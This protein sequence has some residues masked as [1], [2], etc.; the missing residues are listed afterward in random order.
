MTG[1]P[2]DEWG[3][4]TRFLESARLAFARERESW[5]SSGIEYPEQV[6]ITAPQ[7]HDS[8]ALHKHMDAVDDAETLDGSVLVHSY[9]LAEA[10]AAERMQMNSR[11]LAGIEDWGCEAHRQQW[12]R[13]D[14][15]EGWTRGDRRSCGCAKRVRSWIAHDRPGGTGA[16]AGGRRQGEASWLTR[17]VELRRTEGTSS[18]ASQPSERRRDSALEATGRR[19]AMCPKVVCDGCGVVAVPGLVGQ[20]H[21]RLAPDLVRMAADDAGAGR[22][23]R[24][25]RGRSARYGVDGRARPPAVRHG[26]LR[27]RTAHR[28]R[29]GRRSPRPGRPPGPRGSPASGRVSHAATVPPRAAQRTPVAHPV[30]RTS[31]GQREARQRAG[32]H[33]LRRRSVRT[34]PERRSCPPT[35]SS[36]TSTSSRPTRKRCAAASSS[37][38]LSR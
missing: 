2:Y 9:A 32:G 5:A 35:P 34:R 1:S 15:R 31:R 12:S 28:L 10:A 17:H 6:R 13:L 24:G 30:Q 20:P 26:R 36:T 4:L 14:R 19:E 33:L 3:R 22:E 23:L 27:H 16:T 21:T 7:G 37:T 8:V 11:S 38:A 29:P 25:D 18:P